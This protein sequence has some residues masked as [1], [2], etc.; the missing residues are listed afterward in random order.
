MNVRFAK[1][2]RG[3]ALCCPGKAMQK[4]LATTFKPLL[5]PL[6]SINLNFGQILLQHEMIVSNLVEALFF[7]TTG[8]PT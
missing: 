6:N 4:F 1:Q 3:K 7:H 8:H 5:P 2:P